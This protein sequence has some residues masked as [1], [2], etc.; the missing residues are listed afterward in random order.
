M[1]GRNDP[2]PCGSNKKHKHCCLNKPVDYGPC[3][4]CGTA[5]CGAMVCNICDKRHPHCHDHRNDAAIAMRGHVLRVHPEKVPNVVARLM[6]NE[7]EMA[8]VR[9]QAEQQPEF[10][11]RLMEYIAE[12]QN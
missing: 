6:K 11:K 3:F 9:M 2:C 8:V 1:P 7:A 4:W 5:G 12:R 10:W